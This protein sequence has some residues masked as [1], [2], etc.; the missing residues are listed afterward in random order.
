MVSSDNR[1]EPKA[2]RQ[3]SGD[4]GD[5]SLLESLSLLSEAVQQPRPELHPQ[6]AKWLDASDESVAQL[7]AIAL[8][9]LGRPAES[10]L[11]RGL[12]GDR[13][14]SVRRSAAS[15]L[16]S[17]GGESESVVAALCVALGDEDETVRQL[18]AVALGRSGEAAVKPLLNTLKHGTTV[19][20]RESLEALGV[21]HASAAEASPELQTLLEDPDLVLRLR[22]A[23]AL[24]LITPQ[25][26]KSLHET[27]LEVLLQAAQD[28]DGETRSL[29]AENLGQL[30]CDPE[31]WKQ[32]PDSA[33]RV[34]AC[35]VDLGWDS[36]SNVSSAA[37]LALGRLR[38]RAPAALQ[39]LSESL[40]HTA[41][42]VRRHAL[43]TLAS[44]GPEAEDAAEPVETLQND[45]D[46]DVATL[47]TAT[48]KMIRESR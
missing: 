39:V 28:S 32:L 1:S 17:Q 16:A 31:G 41:P 10:D 29:A 5:D 7:A 46:Q 19:A 45:S 6:L 4:P 38:T 44:W 20:R 26:D 35:L 11:A 23:K 8:G 15:G 47:A 12:E 2:T 48:L 14:L 3:S 18:A 33:D 36:D 34:V 30:G 40:G 37:L 24:A 22:A 43:L 42:E 9:R 27:A 25:T 13:P 21:L